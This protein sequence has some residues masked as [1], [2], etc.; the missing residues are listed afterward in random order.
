[1][2]PSLVSLMCV[3][4]TERT[5]YQVLGVSA[6]ASAD[7]IRRAYRARMRAVH[8]DVNANVTDESPV[9]RVIVSVDPS[10]VLV[11][12]IVGVNLKI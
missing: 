6:E 8:P 7:E 5:H 4:G 1:M 9:E 3:M 10:N 11:V 2:R 12:P